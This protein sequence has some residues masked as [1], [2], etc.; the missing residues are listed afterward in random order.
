MIDFLTPQ[1]APH[2]DVRLRM[3]QELIQELVV[4][5]SVWSTRRDVFSRKPFY[6]GM[7]PCLHKFALKGTHST[8]VCAQSKTPATPKLPASMACDIRA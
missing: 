3:I 8:A 7:G 4:T 5:D 2:H 6:A 1:V